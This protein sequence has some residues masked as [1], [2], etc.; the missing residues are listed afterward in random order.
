MI[1]LLIVSGVCLVI[2]GIFT[3]SPIEDLS[4]PKIGYGE[5]AEILLAT[6]ISSAGVIMIVFAIIKLCE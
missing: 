5:D 2:L 1:A 3:A 6:L 4:N